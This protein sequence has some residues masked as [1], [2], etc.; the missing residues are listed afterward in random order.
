M[1]SIIDALRNADPA[2]GFDEDRVMTSDALLD[3]LD[4]RNL[5]M[6]TMNRPK[7]SPSR[8][9]PRRGWVAAAAAFVAVVVAIAS[10]VLLARG[11]ST[12]ETVPPAT[13]AP[14]TT[15]TAQPGELTADQ[16][17]FLD[18]LATEWSS[19]DVQRWAATLAGDVALGGGVRGT[20]RDEW[21]FDITIG[22][23]YAFTNCV[24]ENSIR[25]DWSGTNDL[26]EKLEAPPRTGT[27]S[28]VADAG[29]VTH[30]SSNV[31][32]RF[33]GLWEDFILWISTQDAEDAALLGDFQDLN[34]SVSPIR[35][36][37]AAEL[38]L[39]YLDGYP[40]SP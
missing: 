9:A 31:D 16:Q 7:T 18:E 15:R 4:E 27:I 6:K 22:Q 28:I 39:T 36:A 8:Q 14:V 11:S 5:A 23:E 38:A 21:E 29:L 20:V 2:L 33:N 24:F 3:L 26:L 30:L 34:E 17:A 10:A 37:A 12:S 35:T 19:G 40:P 32:D 13:Q 25:C 1:S